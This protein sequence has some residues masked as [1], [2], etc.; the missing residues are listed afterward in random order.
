MHKQYSKELPGTGSS[1]TTTIRRYPTTIQRGLTDSALPDIYTVY[2]AFE[3]RLKREPDKKTL[4]RRRLL[5]I[6]Q[7]EKN[8]RIWQRY[9]LGEY[10]WMTYRQVD[11][12][13][14]AL[15]AGL[16]RLA[17]GVGSR[18]AIYGPTSRE[19]TLSMLGCF[20]QGLQVVT[21]YD[22]LGDDGLVDAVVEAET[23]VVIAHVN[24]L[25]RL[26]RVAPRLAEVVRAV[27]YWGD[28]T[29]RHTNDLNTESSDTDKSD[30]IN[31]FTAQLMT[32]GI[33]HV[34]KLEDVEADG[35]QRPADVS[36]AKGTDIALVLFTSGTTGRA[37]GGEI[38]HGGLL[39]VCGAIHELVPTHIDYSTDR[40]L[41][42]LPLSHV[43]AFFVETYCLY[44]GLTIGYG[45]PRTLTD[46]NTVKGCV[47]DLCALC[48]AVL[49]GVPQVWNSVRAAIL[50]QVE[51]RPWFIQNI[52]WGAVTLKSFMVRWGLPTGLLDSVV[53]RR[54]RDA[55]GG[56]LKIAITGGAAISP[57]VQKLIAAAVCPMIQGYGLTEASGL[58]SVQIPGDTTLGNVGAPVPSVEICLADV[59]NAGYF[60]RD[61]CGEICVRGPSV[62]HGYVGHSQSPVDDEGW[63]HT[64][65]VGRWIS[66]GRLQ[67]VD[68]CKN[69]VKLLSGEYVA[70]EALE[71][72]YRTSLL[73]DNICV[74]ADARMKRPCALVNVDSTRVA[75]IA[76]RMGIIISNGESSKD[77]VESRTFV[78]ALLADLQNVARKAGLVRQEIIATIRVDSVLWSPE[79]GL[80]TPAMK[81]RRDAICKRNLVQ[82]DS[83]YDEMNVL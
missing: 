45:S 42:Y 43:L 24:Q 28:A 76:K 4:G 12:V 34:M 32:A 70:L 50:N 55:T 19:W 47:G 41:S 5:G 78:A 26:A 56:C 64:G 62:F 15:G 66:G 11:T 73:V 60:A 54:S 6:T 21:A 72:V 22:T 82:L 71:A 81:L 8:G 80:L 65:D 77:I 74:C 39:S 29:E 61:D 51:R 75:E 48:P 59:P 57:S 49:L 36:V 13:T 79:N 25:E 67:I 2:E 23:R 18:V 1:T 40:V 69:L 30:Y 68:R 16:V 83:M 10:E 63:L 20:S 3:Y 52:F 9:S 46:D 14:R 33:Q 38:S 53:F 27:V 31:N 7:E 37:K 58:V 44:S 17:D 35:R